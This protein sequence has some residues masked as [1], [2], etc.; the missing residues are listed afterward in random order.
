LD[1]AQ[2]WITLFGGRKMNNIF[3]TVRNFFLFV[4]CLMLVSLACNTIENGSA[5]QP[6]LSLEVVEEQAAL[7]EESTPTNT[8]SPTTIEPSSTPT[9]AAVDTPEPTYTPTVTPAP[10]TPTPQ[11]IGLSRINPFPPAEVVEAPNW[12][13]QVLEVVRG[14]AAWAAIQAANRFNDPPQEGMEYLLVKVWARSTYSDD[15]AHSISGSDFKITGDHYILRSRESV[16]APD[17][18]LDADLFTGAESTGWITFIVG[19]EESKLVLIF[20]ELFNFD[21]DRLRFIA[22]EEGTF[23]DIPPELFLVEPTELGIRRSEPAPL[24]EMTITEEWV[25]AVLEVIRG[26]EAWEMTQAA[27]RFNDPPE[28]GFEYVAIRLHA[29]FISSQDKSEEIGR[30]SFKITGSAGELYSLPSVVGPSPRLNAQLYPGGEIE[31]WIVMQVLEDETD[32]L[33]VFEPLFDFSNRNR[34]FLSL[35]E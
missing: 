23:L 21:R 6:T 15:E 16:V 27:N 30:S 7:A 11:P 9:P 2:K 17:P 13:I 26:D 22:L 19:Q 34:R 8:P 28:E 29:Q 3:T 18:R 31:G 1:A 14:E 10:P 35:E 33:L 4:F 32:L 5:T 24:G 25:V 20:D 12:D